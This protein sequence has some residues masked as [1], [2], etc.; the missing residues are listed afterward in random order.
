MQ[1]CNRTENIETWIRVTI[2]ED[3]SSYH[4]LLI[5]TYAHTNNKQTKGKGKLKVRLNKDCLQT[6]CSL[7]LH[8]P[9]SGLNMYCIIATHTQ[10]TLL[11]CLIYYI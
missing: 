5:Y 11:Q 9:V 2:T 7:C 1:K 6:W 10:K 4:L 3:K 8:S